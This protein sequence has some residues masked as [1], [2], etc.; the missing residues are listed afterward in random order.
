ME[1]GQLKA[2]LGGAGSLR[3]AGRVGSANVTLAGSGSFDSPNLMAGD[4]SIT[5]GGSGTVRAAV[6]NTAHIKTFGSGGIHLSGGA[7]CTV[8]KAGSGVVD[9]S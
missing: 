3:A 2:V 6:T 9:C 1:V 8:N 4:A 5:S 7:K